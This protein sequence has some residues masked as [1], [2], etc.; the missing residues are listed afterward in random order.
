LIVETI[1]VCDEHI[2]LTLKPQ[3]LGVEQSSLWKWRIAR[4]PRK[5]FREAKLRIDATKD[6]LQLDP[7]LIDLLADAH[8]VQKLVLASPGLSLNQIA[9]REGCC[10]K[11]LAKLLPLS[12]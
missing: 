12:F 1:G 8:Q 4:P 2:V 9:R 5:P 11:Q 3:S 6:R 10:R 7:T